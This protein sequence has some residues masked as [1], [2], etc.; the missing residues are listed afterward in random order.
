[1]MGPSELHET[2]TS[3]TGQEEKMI[4]SISFT[5]IE[6]AS[7]VVFNSPLM[8]LTASICD[9]LENAGI[10]AVLCREH[11]CPAVVVPPENAAETRQLIATWTGSRVLS[12]I[13]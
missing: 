12:G 7:I 10:P 13:C 4:S 6:R 9:M 8:T 3:P 5:A 1:M 2:K 11:G